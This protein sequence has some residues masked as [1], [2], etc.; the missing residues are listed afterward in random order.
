MIK[1]N[2]ILDFEE[3]NPFG[4]CQLERKKYADILTNIILTHPDGFVLAI[5][6]KWGTGKTTFIRMWEQ[7]LKENKFKTVLFNAWENDFENNALTALMGELKTLTKKETEKKFKDVLK[8]GAILTKNILPTLIGAASEKY[9]GKNIKELAENITKGVADIFESEVNE[10][11]NK[12]KSIQEFKSNLSKFIADTWDEKPIVFIIDELDRCRPDYAVTI[13]E[14]IK[15]FFSIPN[16]VFV[17]S[18]D[19][20]QLGHAIRGVYGSESIDADEYLRR[21]IDIEYSIPDPDLELYINYLYK[22][23][24]FDDFFGDKTRTCYRDF[25]DDGY[26]FKKF[27]LLLF[28]SKNITLRKI[29]KIF[30]HSILSIKIFNKDQFVIPSLYLFLITVKQVDLNVFNSIRQKRIGLQDLLDY[31]KNFFSLSNE[32]ENNLIVDLESK[33]IYFYNNYI[34]SE[35]YD[36]VKLYDYNSSTNSYSSDYKSNFDIKNNQQYFL[37]GIN[38]LKRKNFDLSHLL[39]KIE[40]LENLKD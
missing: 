10:Y 4:Q 20:E 40:L 11:A 3:G 27:S 17:L 30:S 24:N 23:Y 26:D 22:H 14:Q 13:L 2:E 8:S 37:S 16:I 33:L 35:R 32:D 19:K 28:K 38:E 21:F 15:H 25:I 9:I 36:S 18:I 31:V 6:N 29:D 39:N 12:K 5:N 1:R 34:N 7:D